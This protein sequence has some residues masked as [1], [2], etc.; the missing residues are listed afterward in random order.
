MYIADSLSRDFLS[1]KSDRDSRIE[2]VVI[3]LVE[4][5]PTS[6]KKIGNI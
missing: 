2:L 3:E 4:S 6:I 1:T 5:F